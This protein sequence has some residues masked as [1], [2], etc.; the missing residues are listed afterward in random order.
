MVLDRIWRVSLLAIAVF[1]VTAC[2][3][4]PAESETPDPWVALARP[5]ELPSI[6]PGDSCPTTTSTIDL[7]GI[8]PILGDGPIYPAFLGPDGIFSL[9]QH[10]AGRQPQQ[11]DGRDWWGKKILWLSDDT[12]RGIAVVRGERI[13][14]EGEILFYTTGSDYDSALRLTVE[15]WVYGGSPAGWREW[16][17]GTFFPDPGCYAYQIDG[18]DFTDIV[19]IQVTT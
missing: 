6:E 2:E 18:E 19:V 7:E 8:G 10:V 14:S 3:G 5:L 4:K 17:S 12:Y 1:V 13:D 16:N 11:I 9:G 15:P